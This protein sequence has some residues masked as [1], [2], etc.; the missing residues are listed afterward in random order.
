MQKNDPLKRYIF[1]NQQNIAFW[2]YM[3]GLID[4]GSQVTI[5]QAAEMYL[6][7]FPALD[8][9]VDALKRSYTRINQICLSINRTKN[10]LS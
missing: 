2:G 4:S 1:F 3:K 5:E 7:H 9:E 6:R 8:L 10:G